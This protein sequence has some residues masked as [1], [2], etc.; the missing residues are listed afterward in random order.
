VHAIANL[1][2]E[3]KARRIALEIDGQR[4]GFRY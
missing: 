1:S 2:G 3:A 4:R